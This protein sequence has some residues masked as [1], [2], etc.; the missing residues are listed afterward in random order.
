M[1]CHYQAIA[2][3][4]SVVDLNVLTLLISAH[5]H[6]L[7]DIFALE[8]SAF[9]RPWPA[10]NEWISGQ[11]AFSARRVKTEEYIVAAGPPANSSQHR[12]FLQAKRYNK[13]MFVTTEI[14]LSKFHSTD[15]SNNLEP[16]LPC[17]YMRQRREK[18]WDRNVP[19]ITPAYSHSSGIV[20]DF[21]MAA[22]SFPRSQFRFSGGI[23]F[24]LFATRA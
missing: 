5:D 11:R 12:N 20:G 1:K 13:V 24:T 7:T 19:A 4:I 23:C 16:R 18:A 3:N 17:V 8:S 2:H 21:K 15:L 10:F 9:K 14:Q 22:T 6:R